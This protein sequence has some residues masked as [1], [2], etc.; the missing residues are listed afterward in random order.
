MR[1]YV[2]DASEADAVIGGDK[3]HRS[4]LQLGVGCIRRKYV[5]ISCPYHRT[6]QFSAGVSAGPYGVGVSVSGS[7]DTLPLRSGRA[8]VGVGREECLKEQVGPVKRF[9]APTVPHKPSPIDLYAILVY[10]GGKTQRSSRMSRMR[11]P[12][13]PSVPLKQ[14]IDLTSKIHRTCRTNVITRENAVHEMGYSGLTGRSMKVLAALLQFGLLEKT[15][16]GDVKVTQ[17][18]V[19]ILHG[20]DPEDRNE[21]M[22]DAARA[23]Q[24]FQDILERFP[25]GI[26]SEGVI[27]SYLIQQDFIDAAIGPAI[28]AFMETYRAV[29]HIRESE[30]HGDGADEA[31]DSAP[32]NAETIMHPQPTPQPLNPAPIPAFA[33]L[34]E[35]SLNKI[36]MNIQGDQVM[37]SGLLNLKGLAQ[38]EQRINALKLLLTPIVG[39]N[40][41]GADT[42]TDTDD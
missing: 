37:I 41:T 4:Q 10:I 18:A 32:S 20:I 33:A 8:V 26:P 5:R 23:P 27:R 29:E 1:A 35:P 38:L 25:D 30:S 31:P 17:R 12:S 28:N 2:L 19:E 3:H 16:K 11:S 6:P 36:N 7:L 9:H 34:P 22:L 42:D 40:D 39:A 15:G 24:L 13:Y 14:A 21:A